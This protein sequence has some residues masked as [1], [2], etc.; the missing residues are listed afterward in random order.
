MLK[1]GLVLLIVPSVVLMAVFF[2]DQST[3]EACL[4]EG[5]SFN[6]MLSECDFE[7]K[8]PFLP[9]MAR[10]PMLV[11]GSMLLSVAGLVLCMKG[12]LWRPQ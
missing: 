2:I 12:L 7:E 8:H 10:Y 3:V 4:I 6:Y 9:L 11:N 1:I 5:G